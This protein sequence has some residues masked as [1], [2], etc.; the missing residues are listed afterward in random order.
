MNQQSYV[1]GLL[2]IN[3]LKPKPWAQICFL[4]LFFFFVSNIAHLFDNR[5]GVVGVCAPAFSTLTSL[6]TLHLKG[7]PMRWLI[8]SRLWFISDFVFEPNAT[9]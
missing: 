3:W 4:F 1:R 8:S 7:V 5:D 2:L 9:A 6:L